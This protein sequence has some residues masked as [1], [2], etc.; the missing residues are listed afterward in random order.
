MQLA[1]GDYNLQMIEL[2]RSDEQM[3]SARDDPY[4][5]ANDV[6]LNS[7]LVESLVRS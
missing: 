3:S 6:E 4:R 7:I 1:Q 2:T 5:G